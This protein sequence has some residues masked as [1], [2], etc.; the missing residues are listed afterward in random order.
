MKRWLACAV[1]AELAVAGVG[2]VL[3]TNDSTRAPSPAHS[4]TAVLPRATDA[5]SVDAAPASPTAG[6]SRRPV[7]SHQSRQRGRNNLALIDQTHVTAAAG[8]L[9]FAEPREFRTGATP[10]TDAFNRAEGDQLGFQISRSYIADSLATGNFDEDPR[11]NVDVVQTNVLA[12]TLS[13]FRG[14]G[15]GGFSD[16]TLI[17]A[18]SNPTFVVATDLDRD[19]H[20]DLAIVDAG[21]STIVILRGDGHGG[22]GITLAIPVPPPRSVAVGDFNGDGVADLA[23]ASR[24]SMAPAGVVTILT[25]SINAGTITFTPSQSIV[26]MK[27]GQP[28]GANVVAVADFDGSGR[29]DLAVGAGTSPSSGDMAAGATEPTGDDLLVFLNR[30]TA[31]GDAFDS[32]PSQRFRVGA[33]PNEIA[34]GDWN[35]DAHPDLAVLSPQ[36]GDL[37]SLLGDRAGHF[38]VKAINATVGALPRSLKV[39]DFNGDGFSDLATASF[40]AST[41]SVVRGKGDGSFAPADDFWA[42]NGA[43]S[44]EVALFDGDDRPDIVTGRMQTDQMALLVNDSPRPSD[45]VAV[46]RDIPYVPPAADDQYAAH[47]R[48]D[49]FTPPP[50]TV[51]FAGAGKA[52]PVF[53]FAHG[54]A[55]LTGDKSML[56]YLMRSLAREGIVA[57]T[58]DY[59]LTSGTGIDDQAGDYANAFRWLRANVAT[60]GGDPSDIVIGGTSAGSAAAARFAGSATF[61][62]EQPHIRGVFHVGTAPTA[63]ADAATASILPPLLAIEGDHGVELAGTAAAVGLVNV[64]KARGTVAEFVQVADR[65]HLTV[66]S[67]LARDGDPG[68]VALLSFL[69]RVTR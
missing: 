41:V 5:G 18:G 17:R 46:T 7:P 8:Q 45:G 69:R 15:R 28:T 42:G 1:A 24:E 62:A 55:S 30:N 64:A 29:D 39:G 33:T 65:D 26:S 67:D 43:S 63:P 6:S 34:V 11:G 27:G 10:S 36:S 50:G 60:F 47:H 12:G 25:G 13:V 56:S 9:S 66:V 21:A 53:L 38:T 4:K 49:L 19:R 51:S 48:L 54:G 20:L 52:Y 14:D 57:V 3:V 37:V 32:S 44:V 59:R 58:T 31:S 68:R 61:A 22:F 2:L 35:N 40:A 23:V 16:P